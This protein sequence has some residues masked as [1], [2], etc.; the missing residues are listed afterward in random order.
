MGNRCYMIHSCEKRRWYIEDFLVPSMMEQGISR[1]RIFVCNDDNGSGNLRMFIKSM[2]I[3][4][5]L[6]GEEEDIWHL[7]DDIMLSNDF[8]EIAEN[9]PK[10]MVCSGACMC[11]KTNW[12]YVGTQTVE[13]KWLSFQAIQIP[14]SYALEFIDWWESE[15]LAK[16]Q[17]A[18]K[19]KENKYD[20]FFFWTFMSRRHH[21]DTVLNIVP[22]IVQ[23]ID[24]MIGGS[25]VQTKE[26]VKWR[27]K[28][29]RCRWWYEEDREIE[30]AKKIEEY[31]WQK[32]GDQESR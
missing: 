21:N 7:Q 6:F 10:H 27:G 32:W 19:R 24:Y 18:E 28:D 16:N 23:H 17:L 5:E 13:H 11:E 20:D 2:R 22:N 25:M 12:K 4:A 15:V 3:S 26:H 30:L 1:D 14:N 9:A 29:N 31:K 8:A